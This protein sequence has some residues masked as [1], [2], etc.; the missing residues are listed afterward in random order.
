M[1]GHRRVAVFES[2]RRS[3]LDG[4]SVFLEVD[5]EVSKAQA[6]PSVS[7]FLLPTDPDV[8]LSATSPTSCVPACHHVSHHNDNGL[9]LKL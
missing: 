6:R 2:I 1:F 8:E 4:G 5:F 3:G 9:N 7:L